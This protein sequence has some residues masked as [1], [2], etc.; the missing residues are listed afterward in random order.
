MN[1]NYLTDIITEPANEMQFYVSREK[2]KNLFDLYDCLFFH[3]NLYKQ[4]FFIKYKGF[5]LTNFSNITLLIFTNVDA[6]DISN[7]PAEY[8]IELN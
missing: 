3:D 4:K 5:L 6:E 8:L 7:L 1:Q 2:G